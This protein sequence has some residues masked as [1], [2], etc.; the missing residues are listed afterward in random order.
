M[1]FDIPE[2][3]Y[4][5]LNEMVKLQSPPPTPIHPR[6]L[7][8]RPATARGATDGRNEEE[9]IYKSRFRKP[10]LFQLMEKSSTP[11][12]NHRLRKRSNS[13][14]F[15][16]IARKFVTPWGQVLSVGC[17][18]EQRD[19]DE[20]LLKG[21]RIHNA[22]EKGRDR[23]TFCC[24]EDGRILRI[25]HVSSRGKFLSVPMPRSMPFICS[26]D[27]CRTGMVLLAN[28]SID[29]LRNCSMGCVSAMGYKPN[30]MVGSYSRCD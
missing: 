9:R 28:V 23:C 4:Q 22:I 11:V 29:L 20:L 19:A 30:I 6:V 13:R 26:M 25:L 14:R 1:E 18:Q 27:E 8:Y 24:P 2:D 10:R 7:D 17:T 12:R 15:H 16:V 3:E 21:T 5:L